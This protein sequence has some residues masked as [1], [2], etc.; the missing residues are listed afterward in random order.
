MRGVRLRRSRGFRVYAAAGVAAVAFG[1]AG[2]SSVSS[3]VDQGQQALDQ[4]QQALDQGRE[5]AESAAGSLGS[6]DD[7]IRAGTELAA[8]CAAAQ[9]AWVPGV[10][11]EEARAAIDEAVGIVDG[12]AAGSA[13]VPG[14]TEI[15]S[16]LDSARTALAADDGSFVVSR[17]TLET[18]CLLVMAGG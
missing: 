13:N 8:A 2:C 10:S 9:A 6:A 4:G 12:V 15:G 18:A 3:A 14:A 11:P 7:L 5:L 16:A 1:L 17:G